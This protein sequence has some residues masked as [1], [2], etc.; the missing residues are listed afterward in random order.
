MEKCNAASGEDCEPNTTVACA[1]MSGNNLSQPLVFQ[2]IFMERV[3]GGRRLE[4]LYGKRLPPAA[5]HR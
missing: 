2:P 1:T 4:S 3:W 5:T